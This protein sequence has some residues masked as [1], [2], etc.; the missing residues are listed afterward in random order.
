MT[1]V[2][3]VYKNDVLVFSVAASKVSPLVLIENHDGKTLPI[4]SMLRLK[5]SQLIFEEKVQ[6]PDALG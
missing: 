4:Y 2:I 6:I 1:V 3:F 5:K